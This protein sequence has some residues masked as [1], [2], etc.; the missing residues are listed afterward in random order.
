M[1]ALHIAASKDNYIWSHF[2]EVSQS[3]CQVEGSVL[4]N[5]VVHSDGSPKG[6][7]PQSKQ[8]VILCSYALLSGPVHHSHMSGFGYG[9]TGG[10]LEKV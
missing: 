8:L 6:P 2:W 5:R 7:V 9:W 4:K 3:S 1:T 10:K